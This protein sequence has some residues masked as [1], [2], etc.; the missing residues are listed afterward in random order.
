M[1]SKDS[2]DF[3]EVILEYTPVSS[4]IIIPEMMEF[5]NMGLTKLDIQRI[6]KMLL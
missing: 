2:L 6:K 1:D 5:E 4:N 3:M